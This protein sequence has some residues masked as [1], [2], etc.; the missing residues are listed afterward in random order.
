V[1]TEVVAT[2]SLGIM[3]TGIN[4]EIRPMGVLAL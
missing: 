3:R 2:Q 4:A 1:P